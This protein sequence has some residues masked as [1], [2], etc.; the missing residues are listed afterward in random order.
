MYIFIYIYKL[1]TVI[2]GDHKAPL[3]IAT[4]LRYRGVRYAFPWIAPLYP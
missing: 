4:T 1:A 2:K 3:S